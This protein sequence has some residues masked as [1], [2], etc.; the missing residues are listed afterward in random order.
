[1]GPVALV[2]TLA[3]VVAPFF[4]SILKFLRSRGGL[5]GG[6]GAAVMSCK[7]QRRRRKQWEEEK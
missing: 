5:G 1:L 3:T 4:L 2:A 7:N 6:D